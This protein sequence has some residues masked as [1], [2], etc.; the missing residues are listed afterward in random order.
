MYWITDLAS[1]GVSFMA[2][3][4][5]EL[6]KGDRN[7]TCVRRIRVAS[8]EAT[9]LAMFGQGFWKDEDSNMDVPTSRG[10]RHLVQ[11]L[12]TKPASTIAQAGCFDPRTTF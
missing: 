5:L 12:G 1:L 7:T 4:W 2:P 6:K 10:H 9:T 8:D 3:M 11:L